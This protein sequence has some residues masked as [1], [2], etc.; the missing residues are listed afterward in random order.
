MESETLNEIRSQIEEGIQMRNATYTLRARVPAQSTTTFQLDDG[1]IETGYQ[2]VGFRL[3]SIG[4]SNIDNVFLHTTDK[5]QKV[6]LYPPALTDNRQ[7]AWGQIAGAGSTTGYGQNIIIDPNHVIVNDLYCS[8]N[9]SSAAADVLVII[10]KIKITGY[11]NIIYQIKE[12]AQ[13]SLE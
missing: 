12:R 13:G 10:K 7:I 9:D 11:E 4:S 1:D 8:N 2:V 5:N 6:A 3:Y